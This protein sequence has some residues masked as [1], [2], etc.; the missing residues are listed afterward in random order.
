MLNVDRDIIAN[1]ISKIVGEE[2]NNDK[3]IVIFGRNAYLPIIINALEERGLHAKKIID[4]DVEKSGTYWGIP[5]C[6]PY[7]LEKSSEIFFIASRFY[8]EMKRQLLELGVKNDAIYKVIDVNIY[9]RTEKKCEDNLELLE[10][11]EK[12]Y[13][14]IITEYGNIPVLI[15]PSSSI[16]DAFLPGR[17]IPYALQGKIALALVRSQVI[18]KIL[19]PLDNLRF[20]ILSNRE[21]LS[22]EKYYWTN[23][24]SLRNVEFMHTTPVTISST[25]IG[26]EVISQKGFAFA[27]AFGRK[28]LKHDSPEKIDNFRYEGNDDFN[29]KNMLNNIPRG[30]TIIIAPFANTMKEFPF[31]FWKEISDYAQRKEFTVCTNIGNFEREKPIEGTIALHCEIENIRKVMEL[32]G[33]VIM[34]RSGLSDILGDDNKIRKIVIYGEDKYSFSNVFSFNDLRKGK[35]DEY[36][37]QIIVKEGNPDKAMDDIKKIIDLW[38]IEND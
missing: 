30:K 37:T 21:M 20:L 9:K 17:H 8:G 36:A 29:I 31:H 14:R 25:R 13:D 15:F 10:E 5:V 22:I 32:A 38:R 6:Q 34:A 12:I 26:Y 2:K 33:Y 7:R 27:Q 23:L 28:I 18:C 19:A 35:I 4:N 24:E 11:G 16:G 1:R 3:E